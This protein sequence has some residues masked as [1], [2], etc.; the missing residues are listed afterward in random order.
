MDRAAFTAASGVFPFKILK[1][2]S[3]IDSVLDNNRI[4]PVHLQLNPTNK[5]NLK[6]SFCSCSERDKALEL[7]LE[8]IELIFKKFAF[9][10]CKAVTIT[11]GGEPL[12]HDIEGIAE[13]ALRYSIELGLVTNG[14]LL[15]ETPDSAINKMTWVRVSVSDESDL[16]KLMGSVESK[17]NCHTDWSF[18]YV[19]AANPSVERIAKVL[20]VA[21]GWDFTHVRI[22]NDILHPVTDLGVLRDRVLAM[23]TIDRLAIWQ[24]RQKY[25]SGTMRCLI[26][27]L[28]PVIAADGYIY[29][30]CG[31]QYA[32]NVPSRNYGSAMKM[33][34]LDDIDDIWL[35]QNH[36]DGSKCIKCYYGH[37]NS[38]LSALTGQIKHAKFV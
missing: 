9:H 18:S 26:S 12:L 29:P 4:P 22:V 8:Q 28:K 36:F 38:A 13:L 35:N 2:K 14:L 19:V 30:C 25:E 1:I 17:I 20:G 11:G 32:E 33:G 6:C 34:N 5:C 27:L 15:H 16:D 21:E 23:G 7:S 3:L 10:G 24:D 31:T 37:Y